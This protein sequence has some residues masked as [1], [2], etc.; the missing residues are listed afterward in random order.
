MMRYNYKKFYD[1]VFHAR[2]H[3]I[4]VLEVHVFRSPLRNF[5]SNKASSLIKVSIVCFL[6][7]L[8]LGTS[9]SKQLERVQ[10]QKKETRQIEVGGEL[11]RIEIKR[12]SRGNPMM[13]V[14]FEKSSNYDAEKHEWVPK[15]DE[16]GLIY[17]TLKSLAKVEKI[18]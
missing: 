6:P 4:V 9:S 17:R 8:I 14:V 3:R 18:E 13:I 5:A 7:I 2:I 12:G 10:K 11:V 15:L 1:L 16:V